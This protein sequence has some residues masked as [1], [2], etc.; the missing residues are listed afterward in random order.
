MRQDKED[1]KMAALKKGDQAPAFSLVDQEGKEVKL[2]DFKGKKVR[3]PRFLVRDEL[4][5]T[6]PIGARKEWLPALR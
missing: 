1:H 6:G 4:S 2:S 5:E 3:V